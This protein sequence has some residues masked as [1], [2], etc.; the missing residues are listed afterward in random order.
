[1]HKQL[2]RSAIGWIERLTRRPRT[3]PSHQ[4]QKVRRPLHPGRLHKWRFPN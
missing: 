4:F 1:M 3:A 2:R